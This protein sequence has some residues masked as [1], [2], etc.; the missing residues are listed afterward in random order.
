MYFHLRHPIKKDQAE[1]Y[2]T[3]YFLCV[4]FLYF[5]SVNHTFTVASLLI[6]HLTLPGITRVFSDMEH[7]ENKF[8]F[9]AS[10]CRNVLYVYC[11]RHYEITL[12]L[13]AFI[14]NTFF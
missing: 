3:L 9:I 7:C 13:T 4:Y 1:F 6:F 8:T 5:P 2:V 14:F 12:C 11:C 10:T